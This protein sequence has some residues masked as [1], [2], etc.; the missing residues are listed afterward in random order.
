MFYLAESVYDWR[1]S[2]LFVPSIWVVPMARRRLLILLLIAAPSP[3][4]AEVLDLRGLAKHSDSIQPKYSI[5]FQ[6]RG[7]IPGHAF[8][9]FVH[10]DNKSKAT[11]KKAFGYYSMEG[12][13]ETVVGVVPGQLIDEI[14][15]PAADDRPKLV[16]HVL[17]GQFERASRV[18]EKWSSKNKY[19][20][21]KEDCVTFVGE[22]AASL[23]MTIPNRDSARTPKVFV[24]EL[25]QLNYYP[26]LSG[27]WVGKGL[28]PNHAGDKRAFFLAP[29]ELAVRKRSE[30]D[31]HRYIEYDVHYFSIN[32]HYDSVMKYDRVTQSFDMKLYNLDHPGRYQSYDNREAKVFPESSIIFTNVHYDVV[33]RLRRNWIE[34]DKTPRF[35]SL[36]K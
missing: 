31:D 16:V 20:L 26:D 17:K 7:T 4:F 6:A 1:Y 22:V 29:T 27:K 18:L 36:S 9:A 25:I 24:H 3:C 19:H 15:K 33:F 21:G 8:V 12:V 34:A 28:W 5:V 2:V 30:S 23:R 35:F 10:E 14:T 32:A 13:K 11:V